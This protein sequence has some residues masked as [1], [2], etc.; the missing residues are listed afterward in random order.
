MLEPL[1][2]RFAALCEKVSAGRY[3]QDFCASD[4]DGPGW[5]AT[6]L[7]AELRAAIGALIEGRRGSPSELDGAG[8]TRLLL[9]LRRAEPA[10]DTNA[11]T[12]ASATPTSPRP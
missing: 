5:K 2:S 3:G 12:S 8:V 10:R 9:S 1:I 4:P 7:E 6:P 11:P